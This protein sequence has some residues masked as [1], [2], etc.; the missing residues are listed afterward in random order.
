MVEL[1]LQLILALKRLFS[2][3]FVLIGNGTGSL[4]LQ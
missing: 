1:L 4:V 2:M 3:G